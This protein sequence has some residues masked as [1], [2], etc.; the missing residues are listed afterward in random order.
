MTRVFKRIAFGILVDLCL[1]RLT[2]LARR[3][4]ETPSRALIV[5]GRLQADSNMVRSAFRRNGGGPRRV[6]DRIHP[7]VDPVAF[8]T[9]HEDDVAATHACSQRPHARRLDQVDRR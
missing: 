6:G 9:I 3:E 5:I 1:K 4:V 7:R 2:K 8:L